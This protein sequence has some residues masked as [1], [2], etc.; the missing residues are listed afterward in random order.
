MAAV[1]SHALQLVILRPIPTP[2]LGRSPTN[3]AAVTTHALELVVSKGI[4][5]DTKT[6]NELNFPPKEQGKQIELN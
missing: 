3:V 1:T 2:T 5:Q 6:L 4:W